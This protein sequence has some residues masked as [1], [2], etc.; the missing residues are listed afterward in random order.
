MEDYGITNLVNS[1]NGVLTFVIAFSLY[2]AVIRFYVD[3]KNDQE[4][5]NFNTFC[6]FRLGKEFKKLLKRILIIARAFAPQ[7]SIGAIRPTKIAK[8]LKIN[9]NYHVTVLTT[10]KS[11]AITDECLE[12]DIKYVDNIIEI[13]TKKYDKP[14]SINKDIQIN[15]RINNEI[16]SRSKVY[17]SIRSYLSRYKRYILNLYDSKKFYWGSLKYLKKID[18]CKFDVVFSTYSPWASH[19]IA[20]YIKNRN[21]Y[22]KWIADFRDPVFREFEI[23]YG[24]K[25][26][27]KNFV[28][29]V[30]KKA[31]IIIAVSEGA[32]EELYFNEH[33]NKYIIPNGFD[34]EDLEDIE[35]INL[36]ANDKLTF[37]YLGRLYKGKSDLSAIFRALKELHDESL[38]HK[39]KIKIIYAGPSKQNFLL[40]LAKF[41]LSECTETYD[42]IERKK[43][44]QIQLNSDVLLLASWNN[45]GNTGI[46]TSKFLEYMMMNKPI[47]CAISGNLPNS[48]VKSMINEANIGVCYEQINDKE[49]YLILKK[50][51]LEQYQRFDS[52]KELLFRP[53]KQYVEK[54]SYKRI[55]DMVDILIQNI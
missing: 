6:L 26:Y 31:D 11:N 34:I 28:R 17:Q 29:S 13:T 39:E 2:S 20:R 42:L 10:F 7:N 18:L 37:A 54:Y 5:L 38:I 52:G 22:I 55:A 33:E 12:Q 50:Y 44:L 40:Q 51:I 9:H 45:L 21:P 49:D 32:L 15:T 25:K 8:Y 3:Y 48:T 30:C 19:E 36:K 16:S 4:Q 23:P 35:K 47:I 41:N 24:F 43:A 53:N 1:F 27:S 14:N 46:V